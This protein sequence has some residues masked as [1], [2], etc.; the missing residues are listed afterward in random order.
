MTIKLSKESGSKA[1]NNSEDV[2][3]L[4]IFKERKQEQIYFR[5]IL[6]LEIDLFLKRKL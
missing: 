2:G 5:R 3:Y 6:E 4:D 1:E